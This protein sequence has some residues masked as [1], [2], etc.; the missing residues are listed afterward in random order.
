MLEDERLIETCVSVDEAASGANMPGERFMCNFLSLF[1]GDGG[2]V[3]FHCLSTFLF[4]EHCFGN[5]GE[6]TH[7]LAENTTTCGYNKPL[8]LC[9]QA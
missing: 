9:V 2:C 6:S 5:R 3:I 4:W 7:H 8:L 1:A